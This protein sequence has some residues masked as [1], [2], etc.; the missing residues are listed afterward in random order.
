MFAE[1]VASV[2]VLNGFSEPSHLNLQL[3]HVMAPTVD[4]VIGIHTRCVPR[5]LCHI[6]RP[7]CVMS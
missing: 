2:G 4:P 7:P 6:E 5:A 1:V 3:Y